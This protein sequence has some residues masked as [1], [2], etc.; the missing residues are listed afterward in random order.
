MRAIDWRFRFEPRFKGIPLFMWSCPV[1][2]VNGDM[3]LTSASFM[4]TDM[5]I[6]LAKS[7]R[8]L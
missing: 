7:A 3:Y 5:N 8:G 2:V 4:R 6:P 1:V